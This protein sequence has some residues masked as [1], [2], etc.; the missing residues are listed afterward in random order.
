MSGDG[1]L[2][3][4]SEAGK[5][6]FAASAAAAASVALS[7]VLQLPRETA[8]G[9][10]VLALLFGLP[11]ALFHAFVFGLPIYMALRRRWPLRWWN[12]TLG[13]F[14]VSSLPLTMLSLPSLLT[15]TGVPDGL[16]VTLYGPPLWWRLVLAIVEAGLPGLVGG[17]TFWLVL[18]RSGSC[19]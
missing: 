8:S 6:A 9:W 5:A 7:G 15:A 19:R 1:N 17:L 13:G 16:P 12:A 3:T 14:L 11:I 18:R 4:A 2:P 10:V